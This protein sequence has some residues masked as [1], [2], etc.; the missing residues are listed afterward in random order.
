MPVPAALHLEQ[1]RVRIFAGDVVLLCSDGLCNMLSRRRMRRVF[2][3]LRGKPLATLAAR[4]VDQ[5]NSA[6]GRD[7]ISVV[8]VRFV[9]RPV[10]PLA[11]PPVE[12]DEADTVPTQAHS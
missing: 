11:S 7:N 12:V 10:S 8:L 1:T 3:T 2:R 4:L 9:D 6:G 5:A